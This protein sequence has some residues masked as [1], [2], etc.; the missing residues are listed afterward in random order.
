VKQRTKD[1]KELI[2]Q[3]RASLI[4][5][6][7]G[8]RRSVLIINTDV[9]EQKKLEM[10]LLRAQRLDGIGTLASGVAHA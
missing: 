8:T 9:T 10:Q 7:D 3:V 6:P 4:S 2:V 1:G 5:N